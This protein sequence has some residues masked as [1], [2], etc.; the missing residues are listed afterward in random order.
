MPMARAT[1]RIGV[2]PGRQVH[3]LSGVDVLTTAEARLAL[4]H[5]RFERVVQPHLLQPSQ[6]LVDPG[7][8]GETRD[9]TAGVAVVGTSFLSGIFALGAAQ[10]S[11]TDQWAKLRPVSSSSW[12]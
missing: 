7:G 4:R 9:P 5:T 11:R 1:S 2:Q 6:D 8:A 10:G 3:Q 12:A